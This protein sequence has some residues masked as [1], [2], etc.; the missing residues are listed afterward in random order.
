MENVQICG[1]ISDFWKH[2]DFFEKYKIFGK[3]IQIFDNNSDFG[4]YTF[5]KKNF[6]KNLEFFEEKNWIWGNFLD[7]GNNFRN[8]WGKNLILNFEEYTFGCFRCLRFWILKNTLL[9]VSYV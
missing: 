2:W 3:K 5:R 9:D 7:F 6:Q 8:I 1:K 4:K